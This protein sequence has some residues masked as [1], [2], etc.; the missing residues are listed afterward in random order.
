MILEGI[1]VGISFP[2]CFNRAGK[3]FGYSSL[4]AKRWVNV[5][6]RYKISLQSPDAPFKIAVGG[7]VWRL[8]P[9]QRAGEV[10]TS[11]E[12]IVLSS[13]RDI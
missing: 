5:P 7:E 3:V 10:V 1:P 4:G 11:G 8:Y 12:V 2:G 9:Q 13:Y 6:F